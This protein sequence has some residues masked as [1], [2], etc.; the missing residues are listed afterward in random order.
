MQWNILN[1]ILQ[2][3]WQLACFL[4]NLFLDSNLTV[5]FAFATFFFF[6]HKCYFTL[7]LRSHKI[8]TNKT[9]THQVL[10]QSQDWQIR[11]G[12]MGNS[13]RS[14]RGFSSG[15]LVIV[16]C[17]KFPKECSWMLN[18]V[19]LKMTQ[20]CTNSPRI[21]LHRLFLRCTEITSTISPFNV[22]N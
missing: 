19:W 17:R 16:N 20:V 18:L 22:W 2:T 1:K 3:H 13:P 7:D 6:F 9:R 11:A 4:E 14:R 21:L 10:F 12:R 15:V 8:G 5:F